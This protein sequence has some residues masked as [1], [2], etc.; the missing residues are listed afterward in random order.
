MVQMHED[1]IF[2]QKMLFSNLLF[3]NGVVTVGRVTSTVRQISKTSQ[4]EFECTSVEEY[5]RAYCSSTYTLCF[6]VKLQF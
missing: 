3:A 1:N 5:L 6:N 4:E 2:Q